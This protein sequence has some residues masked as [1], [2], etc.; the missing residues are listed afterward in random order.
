MWNRLKIYWERRQ[1]RL[2][3]IKKCKNLASLLP[4]LQ[5]QRDFYGKQGT[6]YHDYNMY[7]REV[8]KAEQIEQ[9]TKFLI[10]SYEII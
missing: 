1:E 3:L 10:Q 7:Q 2:R 8:E 6:Q 9:I 4:Y 5:S